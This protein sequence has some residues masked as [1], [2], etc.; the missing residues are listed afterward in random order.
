VHQI[1]KSDEMIGLRDA[2]RIL[3]IGRNAMHDLVKSGKIPAKKIGKEWK[4]QGKNLMTWLEANNKLNKSM[5]D[6]QM[7]CHSHN[8]PEQRLVGDW[9]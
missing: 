7:S 8:L 4:I 1:V 2:Q 9:T 5:V 6:F 3:R